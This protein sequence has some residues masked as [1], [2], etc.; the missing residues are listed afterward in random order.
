MCPSVSQHIFIIF[1]IYIYIFPI[2]IYM[3]Y[4]MCTYI[5]MYYMCI[6]ICIYISPIHPY[7]V[8]N[9]SPLYSVVAILSFTILQYIYI[10]IPIIVGHGSCRKARWIPKQLPSVSCPVL[11]EVLATTSVP[12]TGQKAEGGPDGILKMVKPY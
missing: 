11:S 7:S 4:S 5:Y 10:Y 8:P 2:Y 1:P 3:Y 6:Y 9:T 12:V